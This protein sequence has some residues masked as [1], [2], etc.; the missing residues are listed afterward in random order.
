[1]SPDPLVQTRKQVGFVQPNFQAGPRHLN[2][3][4]LPYSA[5]ILWSSAQQNSI[6]QDTF[7]VSAWIFR[8][9]P[10]DQAAEQLQQCQVV[11]FSLYVWNRNY[12]F[13]LAQ[14]I[15]LLNPTVITVFGGP[16]LPHRDWDLFIKYPFIDV[17]VV[18]EGEPAVEE[19]LV[20]VALNQNIPRRYHSQ[21]QTNLD[22]PSPYLTGVFD[23]LMQ[24][25]PDI[26]WM[27]TLE[28]DRGC[29]Y[30]CTFCDWGSMTASK[31]AKFGLQR[32]FAE[33]EWFSEH[34]MKFLTMT[35]ANFG[36]FRQRDL[37]IADQIVKLSQHT[38]Y[39]TGISVSY[40]KNSTSDV[41]EIVKRFKSANIQTGFILSLQTTT[42]EVLTN[43]ER[44]NMKVNNIQEI[45]QFGRQ[46]QIPIYTEIIMG[47]PGETVESWKQNIENVLD[48]GLHN[49]ID[50]FFL[51]MI[52]NAPIMQQV[53]QYQ[54]KSFLAH[55]MFY[56]TAE[57]KQ[58]DLSIIESVSVIQQNSSVTADQLLE[59]FIYT[60]YIMGLHVSGIS[61]I[62]AVYLNR[63]GIG[64]QEFYSGLIQHLQQHSQLG[65]W[66][67]QV[68]QAYREWPHTGFFSVNINGQDLLSWQMVHSIGMLLHRGCQINHYIDLIK[69]Y[70]IEKFDIPVDIAE[71]YVTITQ[72]RIKQWNCYAREPV[73]FDTRTNLFE[74]T[75][76]NA[77]LLH[78]PQRYFS[79]DRF[80][81]FPDNLDQHCDNV[82]YGRRR[83][84]GL[85]IITADDSK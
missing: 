52:E 17:A 2:A 81:H 21:R 19:I 58:S 20:K 72:H 22:I 78:Q 63:Q 40:A 25:H 6:V 1:M 76:H 60:W 47:L 13:Q 68:S 41:F 70:V 38:G 3:F 10:I 14:R 15:K 77:D 82:V 8:R 57:V 53:E 51:N 37:E 71:D 12:C 50:A 24:Q 5:G 23:Q 43:I 49:G 54:I 26:E 45:A 39:P 11:F 84:W 46:H 4:Y 32:V 48:A 28:T 66:Q 74:Y 79:S 55:D 67:K 30:A 56:E 18:G 65:D 64:Y 27:P 83:N 29:P 85:N 73:N 69:Q 62:A 75:Q 34:R 33:L 44:T 59:K 35:N 9:D 16:E 31:V 61:D 80:D 7:E 36:I 42:P